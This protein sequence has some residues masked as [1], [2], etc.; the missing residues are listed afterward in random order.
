MNVICCFIYSKHLDCSLFPFPNCRGLLDH[1]KNGQEEI[2]PKVGQSQQNFLGK[3]N[4]K[5]GKINHQQFAF[6]IMSIQEK[7]CLVNITAVT[8][9]I[10]HHTH[11]LGSLWY[12]SLLYS[13]N[14]LFTKPI[15]TLSKSV[16]RPQILCSVFARTIYT[17]SGNIYDCCSVKGG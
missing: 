15:K 1:N 9:Q 6:I 14:I 2:R 17:R 3:K 13:K 12:E 7:Q 16:F 4:K 8:Q 10:E 5:W 11:T